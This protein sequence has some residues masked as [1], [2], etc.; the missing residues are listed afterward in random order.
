[1][2]KFS[3]NVIN[4]KVFPVVRE[5]PKELV[6]KIEKFKKMLEANKKKEEEVKQE[7]KEKKADDK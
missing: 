7:N 6:E 5:L 4:A 3:D 2:A 1:M